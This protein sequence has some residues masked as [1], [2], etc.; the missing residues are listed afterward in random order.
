MET[1][2][3]SNF[4]AN[5]SKLH[6]ELQAMEKYV[7]FLLESQELSIIFSSALD[8]AED[9]QLT[10]LITAHNPDPIPHTII[11]NLTDQDG[12]F[13]EIDYT[14]LLTNLY[15]KRTF[16]QGEL[17][18]VE[19]YLEPEFETL[20]IKVEIVYSRDGFGFVQ[21]RVTTRTWYNDDNS[22]NPNTKITTKYYDTITKMAESKR[23][24]ENNMFN[25]QDNTI[26]YM[27]ATIG[28]NP[29]DVIAQGRAFMDALDVEINLYIKTGNTSLSTAIQNNTTDTW[30]DNLVPGEA[31]TIRDYIVQEL[32]L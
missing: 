14:I 5:P 17:N 27:V 16:S 31:F 23:R 2:V 30:L 9:T 15:P 21:Y 12:D 24:R 29:L 32:T 1:K 25:V 10:A 13:R 6:D 19:W 20:V 11:E 28:G 3:F 8:T 18:L 4:Q 22:P 7:Y 26:S